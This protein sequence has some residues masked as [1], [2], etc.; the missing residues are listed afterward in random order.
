MSPIPGLSCAGILGGGVLA[1]LGF[2]RGVLNFPDFAEFIIGT[3][4]RGIAP[5]LEIAVTI[6][7]ISVLLRVYRAWAFERIRRLQEDA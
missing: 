5:A 4:T 2:G 3:G 7:C 1:L 6:V